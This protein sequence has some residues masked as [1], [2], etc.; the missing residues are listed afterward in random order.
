MS[1][2]EFFGFYIGCRV[3]EYVIGIALG[4]IVK[5]VRHP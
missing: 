3:L 1:F 5:L 4:V 2:G